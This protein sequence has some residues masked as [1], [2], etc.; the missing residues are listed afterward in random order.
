MTATT[1]TRSSID[2]SPVSFPRV[3]RAEWVKFWTL[4]S[5][6]WAVGLT[7]LAMV[8]ISLLMASITLIA[9]GQEM[10]PEAMGPPPELTIGIAYSFGQVMV[11]VLGVMMIS[12][13]YTTGQIRSTLAAVPTRLPVLAAKAV[14]IAVVGFLLGL[15]GTALSYLVTAPIVGDA[16]AD[17]SDPEVLRL[18]WGAGLYLAAI[19]LLSL[20]VGALLRHTA[21]ALTLILGLLLFIPTIVQFLAMWQDWIATVYRYLPSVAGERIAFPSMGM[22]EAMMG[23]PDLL[24]PWPGFGVLMIYVVVAL[25]AAALLLRRRDA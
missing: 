11:A 7:I 12:G 22:D 21:G 6:Y 18:F 4:R 3:L 15:L 1:A 23:L 14:L 17:L 9:D 16:A 20:G 25:L 13:E 2:V 8:G 10:G 24:D 5:T 19:G